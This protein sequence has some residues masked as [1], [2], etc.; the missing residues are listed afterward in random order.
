MGTLTDPLNTYT[1]STMNMIGWM[2]AKISSSGLR[3]TALRCRAAS[4][5]LSLSSQMAPVGGSYWSAVPNAGA[6][7]VGGVDVAVI[8]SPQR[9][10]SDRPGPMGR[11]TKSCHRIAS[12]CGER[13]SAGEGAATHGLRGRGTKWRH[14]IASSCGERPSAG[15]GAATHGLRGRG[16]KWRHRIASS[17]CERPSASEGAATHGL[18]GRGT[19]LTSPS[20]RGLLAVDGVLRA[21]AGERE[22]DVVERGPA[23]GD[24][25]HVDVGVVELAHDGRH[26]SVQREDRDADDAGVVVVHGGS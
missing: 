13:P 8:G 17:C 10:T 22:E 18:R 16:T 12:S 9:A 6:V 3:G 24:V 20:S 14:R 1:N 7:A 26:R 11:G 21:M 2:V 5:Q 15:E 19:Q 25:A 23:G 4:V